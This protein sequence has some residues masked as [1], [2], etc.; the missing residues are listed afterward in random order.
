M[1]FA[2]LVPAF[3]TLMF[4][5]VLGAPPRPVPPA[6]G[7]D[8]PL[9][10]VTGTAEAAAAPDRATLRLGAVAQ[11]E[12]A[13][14]AQAE[15]SRTVTQTINALKRLGIPEADISTAGIS[16]SPVYSQQSPRGGN[17][18]GGGDEPFT[19]KITAYRAQN[20]VIARL[21]DLKKVGPAIDAAVDAGANEVESL[22]FDLKDDTAAR[23][24]ALKDAVKQARAKAE[25]LAQ[26]AGV[27]LVSL[28][29]L[30]ESGGV[31]SPIP[32]AGMAVRAMAAAA[33]TPV[34]PGQ[35]HLSASVTLRY[36][37]QPADQPAE[38]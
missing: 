28:H 22:T 30:D 33:P 6:A 38:K 34:E 25:A 12:Q 32:Y 19:P 31:A 7:P 35:V 5:A 20:T 16:L 15:V 14:D 9:L 24:Q 17:R 26:A 1:R 3:S 37:I 23:T 2:S 29:D 21:S 4:S 13:A 36:A 18:V 8:V 27:K 10:T 11:A